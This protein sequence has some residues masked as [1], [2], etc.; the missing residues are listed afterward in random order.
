[1]F[2]SKLKAQQSLQV[3]FI[4]SC[5][6]FSRVAYPAGGTFIG[7]YVDGKRNGCGVFEWPDGALNFR[8]YNKDDLIS[9]NLAL[10]YLY[11]N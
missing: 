10:F 1:M 9:G 7:Y 11:I 3:Y 5:L 4:L 6:G 2:I 8:D